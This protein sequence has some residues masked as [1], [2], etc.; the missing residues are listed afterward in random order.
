MIGRGAFS[1]VYKAIWRSKHDE[2]DVFVAVKEFCLLA[3]SPQ[4][5]DM[6]MKE[7]RALCRINCDCLV[8]LEGALLFDDKVVMVLEFMD[9]GSLDDI[10]K[11]RK[12]SG[13]R[14]EE[15]FAASVAFQML[16]GLSYLHRERIIHRDVKP[17]NV[18]VDSQGNVKLCDFGLASICSDHSLQRT[19]VGTTI[20]MAPERLRAQPYGRSSDMWSF[21]LVILEASMH[22]VREI[23]YKAVS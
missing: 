16:W 13:M 3:A 20:Y 2:R 19:M 5:R 4:R 18:L 8:Q 9:R 11:A 6:L 10:I 21:G 12:I 23:M 15:A 14:A 22:S 17:G 7:L 1:Q